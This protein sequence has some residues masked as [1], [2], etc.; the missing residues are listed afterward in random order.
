MH[1]VLLYFDVQNLLTMYV[2]KKTTDLI[3]ITNTRIWKIANWVPAKQNIYLKTDFGGCVK[4]E[5]VNKTNMDIP[6]YS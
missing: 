2:N 3:S 6:M 1:E 4:N 5:D